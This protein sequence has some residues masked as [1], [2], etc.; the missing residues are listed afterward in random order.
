MRR[1]IPFTAPIAT[2]V[3]TYQVRLGQQERSADG[4]GQCAAAFTCRQTFSLPLSAH[5]NWLGK[6]MVAAEAPSHASGSAGEPSRT[7]PLA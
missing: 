4:V 3:S 7:F 6:M 1:P 2:A 5:R